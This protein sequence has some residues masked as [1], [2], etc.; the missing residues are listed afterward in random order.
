M[1]DNRKLV[2][3]ARKQPKTAIMSKKVK[4]VIALLEADGWEH[5]RTR[6]DHRIFMKAGAARPIVVPGALNHS[7]PE[8]TYQSILR[9][10]GLK[11]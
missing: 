3:F 9:S 4:E 8:G 10:A 2:T 6:G 5:K 7:M 11:K 1:L